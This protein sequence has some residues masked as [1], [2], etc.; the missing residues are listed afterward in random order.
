MI[1]V[2]SF[3]RVLQGL[4]WWYRARAL[5]NWRNQSAKQMDR[6]RGRF[7][8]WVWREAARELG[9]SIVGLG[10]EVFEIAVEGMR[11]RV[12]RNF[13]AIDDPVTLLAA[14]NKPLVHRLLSQSHLPIPRYATFSLDR[15]AE[16]VDFL[17]RLGRPCVLKPAKDTGGGLGVTTGIMHRKQLGWASVFASGYC[18]DL[19]IEEQIPGDCY[20]LLFLDGKL[21]DA[22]VRRPPAVVGDGRSTIRDLV[23][24]ENARR[25]EIGFP[26]GQFLLHID[27]DMRRTLAGQ[28]LSARSIPPEGVHVVVKTVVNENAAHENETVHELL[29]DAVVEAGREA[30]LAVGVR[31]AGVDI[32][33]ED[34]TRPLTETGGRIVEVNATPG[35][36]YHYFKRDE[37]LP[38]AKHVLETLCELGGNA[39]HDRTQR[40]TLT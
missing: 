4:R 39:L 7:Y 35:L 6:E 24:R 18:R 31:F 16:A 25:L 34:A 1:D 13:T 15:M 17:E 27:G 32:L 22:I 26:A 37:T 14:C 30:A 33:T 8:E 12:W 23:K 28:G 40:L 2:T 3:P 19:L 11:T 10:D 38:V 20:R 29:C 5:A 21:L 9:G 36:Y